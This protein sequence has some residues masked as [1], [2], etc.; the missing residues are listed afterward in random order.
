[1]T[2]LHS[3]LFPATN[4]PLYTLFALPI[5]VLLIRSI[6]RIYFS[7]L[8]HIPGPSIWAATSSFLNYHAW[9]GTECRTVHALHLKYG[10]I[11][12][13]GPDSVD[14]AD[15]DALAP[16]YVE[17]GGFWKT[18]LY[19]NFDIDG[20][21]SIFSEVDP[22]SRIL[23]AKPVLPLFSTANLRNGSDVI[24]QCVDKMVD[25]M[26]IESCGGHPINVL[27]LTRSLATDTVSAYLF[28]ESYG[29]L[30]EKQDH[31]SASE[32]V[33]SF[34]AVGR[35]WYLPS[36]TFQALE[37][38]DAK[39]W[40]RLEVAH[41]MQRVDSFVKA[42]VERAA[43]DKNS[44]TYPARL[45]DA[46]ISESETRAQCKDLIFAGTDS[47]GMNLATICF[48]L[49][50]HPECY[51]KLRKEIL[52]AK[53][54]EAELQSLPY[55]QGVVKE[56]LRL[57]MANPSRL[58]RLVPVGGWTFKDMY[59]PQST[60]VSCTPYELHLDPSVFEDPLEFKP[61]RW[62]NGTQKM[63]RDLIPFGLGTRQCIARN[64]ATME[65]YCAVQRLVEADVLSGA[66]CCGNKI[67]ILE[68]FNSKVVGE[69]IELQWD[70]SP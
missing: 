63:I 56:G 7:R 15:G 27:N 47:T 23:R 20:H 53:P 10:S 49:A 45:L 44:R 55:L 48:M 36:W 24:Y 19:A 38:L 64:L 42:V 39:I 70:R 35:F 62:Q 31:L 30:G 51:H 22:A 54:T 52:A 14:I 11:V 1:M 34:V 8:S 4:H 67:E 69:K 25:R 46:G 18:P 37:W 28:G 9:N 40:H 43:T 5:F 50:K 16:I 21:K 17:K 12:R 60:A 61:E 2:F 33:D 6:Q 66:S 58:P 65:L 13:T 41:I 26:K 32:M 59:L 57:S 29:G 3:L 68:W